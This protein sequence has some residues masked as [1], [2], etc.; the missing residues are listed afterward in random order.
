MQHSTA[1]KHSCHKMTGVFFAE[2]FYCICDAEQLSQ[3]HT[4]KLLLEQLNVNRH[5]QNL[6][7]QISTKWLKIN[8]SDRNFSIFPYYE[9]FCFPIRAWF[10]KI[11][12][13]GQKAFT[14]SDNF[15][16]QHCLIFPDIF[17]IVMIRVHSRIF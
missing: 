3:H 10:A 12:S 4:K 5:R 1:K 15:L 2:I 17:G 13:D 7:T 16:I 14:K 9:F 8:L 6:H 11:M